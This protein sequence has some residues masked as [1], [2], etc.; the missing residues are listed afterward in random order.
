MGVKAAGRL[1]GGRRYSDRITQFNLLRAATTGKTERWWEG[2]DHNTWL[3]DTTKR[4]PERGSPLLAKPSPII[5][6]LEMSW[7]ATDMES[8]NLYGT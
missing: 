6:I 7:R 8:F 1:G 3:I 2:N 5:F 4:K